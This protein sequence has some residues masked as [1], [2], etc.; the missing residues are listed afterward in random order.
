MSTSLATVEETDTFEETLITITVVSVVVILLL[1]IAIV[2]YIMCRTPREQGS[3]EVV[4]SKSLRTR[5]EKLY[6]RYFTVN[7]EDAPGGVTRD[8]PGTWQLH[9]P[10]SIYTEKRAKEKQSNEGTYYS[11]A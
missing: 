3:Q 6:L 7:D 8:R 1:T 10:G 11:E 5:I 4:N 9:R 2:V